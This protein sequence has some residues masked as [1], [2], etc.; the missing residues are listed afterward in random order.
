MNDD[1]NVILV[2]SGEGRPY[3][4]GP[5][6]FK[7]AGPETQGRYDFFEMT[8]S[9]LTGPGLHV[10]DVQD[11][12]FYVLEGVITVQCGDDI[13]HLGPGD[14][15]SIPPGVA[16]TFDNIRED[17]P[18]VRVI[19]LMTPAGYEGIFAETDRRDDSASDTEIDRI[20]AEY[21]VTYVGPPLRET[22]G[23][24]D[25]AQRISQRAD[26]L[27]ARPSQDTP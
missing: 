4:M 8:L 12:A 17:Q 19:N 3:G 22:L 21:G 2:R 16:H 24:V 7:A 10:H 20:N 25:D 6:L 14:F 5:A 11:D 15:I 9:Y 26:D 1:S 18:P 27:Q 23:L 13:H